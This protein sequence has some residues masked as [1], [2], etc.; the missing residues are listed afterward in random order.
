MNLFKMAQELV[1]LPKRKYEHLLKLVEESKETEQTGG[2]LENR[3]ETLKI[4]QS[5]SEETIPSGPI[6]SK[7][8]E[9]ETAT[10]A[11]QPEISRLYVDKPLSKM[12]FTRGKTMSSKKTSAKMHSNRKKVVHSNGKKKG[13]KLQRWINYTI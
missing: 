9:T 6:D 13:A 10:S 5:K 11:K 3:E 2:Q 4:P 1:V 8:N 12:H 7:K